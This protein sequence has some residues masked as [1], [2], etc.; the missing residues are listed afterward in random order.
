MFR[1][2]ACLAMLAFAVLAPS[3]A[4]AA[5]RG[6]RLKVDD[7]LKAARADGGECYTVPVPR[8]NV[9]SGPKRLFAFAADVRKGAVIVRVPVRSDGVY[10]VLSRVLIGRWGPMHHGRFQMY[11]GGVALPGIYQGWYGSQPAK[12][13]YMREHQWGVAHFK[14]P[15]AD[16]RFEITYL[17]HGRLLFMENL[18]LEP[19]S[20]KDRPA[21][22]DADVPAAPPEAPVQPPRRDGLETCDV[23]RQRGLEWTT[24]VTRA[25]KPVKLDGDLDDWPRLAITIDGRIPAGHGWATPKPEGDADLSGKVGL[26]WDERFL[27]VAARIR[28]DDRMP[29]TDDKKWAGPWSHDGLVL[30]V[31]PPGWLTGSHRSSGLSPRELAFGLNYCSPKA[32]PRPLGGEARYAVR[33]TTDGYTL[34]AALPIERFGWAP[35]RPGD[36]FPFALILVDRDPGKAPGRQFDQYGWNF[37]TGS[38]AGMGEAR[39]LGAESLA[40]EI[41]PEGDTFVV[42]QEI[43]YVGTVDVRRPGM[44][45]AINVVP[46]GKDRPVR[47]IT[48]R[49]RFREAGRYRLIGDLSVGRLKPGRYECRPV[50]ER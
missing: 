10:R 48:V 40:G 6:V 9:P 33:D 42:G 24:F 41:I 17:D 38:T 27:Y 25:A 39:L 37:G 45:E 4:L 34:E 31:H 46:L 23:K 43:R 22:L 47:R 19:V 50:F 36:R 12:P 11:A 30:L 18:R 1:S 3:D 5:R 26:A 14:A 49:H 13:L 21:K 2:Y 7:L 32:D 29:K 28:D 35:A 16:L 20:K 15:A 8:G 44:L